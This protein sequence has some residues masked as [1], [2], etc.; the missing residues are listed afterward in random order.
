MLDKWD[1]HPSVHSATEWWGFK[2]SVFS[3]PAETLTDLLITSSCDA[4]TN[5]GTKVEQ[6]M[7][8]M[9]DMQLSFK[10]DVCAK[11]TVNQLQNDHLLMS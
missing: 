7:V 5:C 1:A 10:M 2:D 3:S 6:I 8:G 11:T 4:S 9:D